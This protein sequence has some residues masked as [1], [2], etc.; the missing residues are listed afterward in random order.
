M[1]A[2]ISRRLGYA[3]YALAGRNRGSSSPRYATCIRLVEPIPRRLKSRKALQDADRFPTLHPGWTD[4]LVEPIAD[5]DGL[6]GRAF[7]AGQS[8]AE[9]RRVRFFEAE[10]RRSQTDRHERHQSPFGQPCLGAE[11][12]VGDQPNP[13]VLR[14]CSEFLLGAVIWRLQLWDIERWLR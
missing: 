7:G 2:C 8:E 14:Q 3:D 1:F 9:N 5:H 13:I 11:R 12:L 10:L 6:A 4:V